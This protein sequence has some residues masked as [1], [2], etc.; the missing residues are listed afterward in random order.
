MLVA[1]GDESSRQRMIAS[2]MRLAMY[3]AERFVEQHAKYEHLKDDLLSEA[4]IGLTEGVDKIRDKGVR[5]DPTSWLS[6]SI[7]MQLRRAVRKLARSVPMDRLRGGDLAYT[8]DNE[9]ETQEAIYACCKDDTDREIVRL[10]G[11]GHTDAEIGALIGLSRG[12][13][14]RT[15]QRLEEKYAKG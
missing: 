2:N 12:A 15:R 3:H 4:F 9:L 1:G 10:R 14:N 6:G 7:R 11:L 5:D 8:P 13:V